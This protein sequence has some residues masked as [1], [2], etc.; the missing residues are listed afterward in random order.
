MS[1]G[2]TIEDA[3]TNGIDTMRGRIESMPPRAIRSLRRPAPRRHDLLGDKDNALP[4]GHARQ[5]VG[6]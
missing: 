5:S 6:I 4:V 1:D 3:I 2:A